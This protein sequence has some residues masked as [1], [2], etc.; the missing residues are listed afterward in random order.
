[1]SADGSSGQGV[2][3]STSPDD[4]GWTAVQWTGGYMN[5]TEWEDGYYA[6]DWAGTFTFRL[7]S[8]ALGGQVF[9]INGEVISDVTL[10]DPVVTGAVCRVPV[11]PR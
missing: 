1:M 11:A 2:I 7:D 4:I 9:S 10:S 8:Y 3:L 5:Y 6:S